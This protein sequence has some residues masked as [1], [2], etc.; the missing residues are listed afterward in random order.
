MQTK[1]RRYM[2]VLR[3]KFFIGNRR[4]VLSLRQNSRLKTIGMSMNPCSLNSTAMRVTD[5]NVTTSRAGLKPFFRFWQILP[6]KIS[7]DKMRV[8]TARS[9]APTI[10]QVGS[11][12]RG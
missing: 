9:A 2:A 4:L 7:A 8:E 1:T 3:V 5:E 12:C 11:V 10:S 6:F